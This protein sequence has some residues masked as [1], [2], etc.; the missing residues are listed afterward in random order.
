MLNAAPVASKTSPRPDAIVNRSPFYYGWVILIAAT[1]GQIMTSPGQTYVN[2][3]FIEHFIRDL[4]LSRALVST[5]YTAGTLLASLALPWIGRQLDLR[6]QRVMVVMISVIFGLSCIWMSFVHSAWM[7]LIGFTLVR[8]WGQ[9]SLSLV[10]TNVINQWWVRRRGPL[11]GI[12][13]VAVALLGVG[14]FPNLVNW[15]IPLYGWRNTCILLG[16]VLILVMAPV[17]YLFYRNRPEDH[18]LLPDGVPHAAPSEQAGETA[19]APSQFQEEHWTLQ[20]AMRTPIYWLFTA[21]LA[22]ISMLGTGL[23]FHIVSIFADNGLSSGL[24]AAAYVPVAITSAVANLASGFLVDRVRLRV[25]MA[26]ALLLQAVSL[27]MVSYLSWIV[28]AM[29]F[30]VVIGATSGLMRTVSTVA[31]AKYYGRR[32]LGSI[33]G[34]TSTVLVASSALGPMPMGLA[35]DL[36]GSYTLTL[37]ILAIIPLLLAVAS[38]FV[39]SPS[40]TP[41]PTA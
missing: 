22:S 27:W 29:L 12:S 9:G 24:A 17:G 7:L 4:D 18:N 20:E 10:S 1:F 31:W 21:G 28:L 40:K 6:G 16:C 33:S 8:M 39:E 19:V 37:A 26:I 2:S 34:V 11:L 13:G 36:L 25:I 15:L 3:I 38:L 5:L 30:G 41:T 14:G 35:R 32:H 23:Q